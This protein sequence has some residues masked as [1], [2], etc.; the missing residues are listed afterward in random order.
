M[1]WEKEGS[2]I[3]RRRRG[4][5]SGLSAELR[6]SDATK[7]RACLALDR[8]PKLHR[9]PRLSFPE[10][11][12][13]GDYS[14]TETSGNNLSG[15]WCMASASS[16]RPTTAAS[17]AAAAASRPSTPLPPLLPLEI[18]VR[19]S[20]D[21][22]QDDLAAL[23]SQAKERFGDVSW[24]VGQAPGEALDDDDDSGSGGDDDSLTARRRRPAR[25]S[26]HS[27][28]LPTETLWGHKGAV[29]PGCLALG[30]RCSR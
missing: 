9:R 11:A 23:F 27:G 19:R 10:L 12:R 22:W 5:P 14:K 30:Q 3:V 24:Q 26:V 29:L 1:N 15:D 17:A 2:P 4:R 18:S 7:A 20:A 28:G 6:P 8:H 21:V 16:L 25:T 13:P